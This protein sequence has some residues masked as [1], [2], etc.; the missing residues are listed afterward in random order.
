MMNARHYPKGAN[1]LNKKYDRIVF[2]NHA[3]ERFQQ[4]KITKDMVMKAIQDPDKREF[5]DDGDTKFI[6][7]VTGREVH[8]VCKPVP[9]ENT[10]L[11]KSAW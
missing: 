10:W 1:L 5:E 6:R 11:V 4:R 8:V 2:T 9:E 7:R 3:K